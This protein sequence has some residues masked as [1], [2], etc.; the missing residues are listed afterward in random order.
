MAP[1]KQK[2]R[3]GTWKRIRQGHPEASAAGVAYVCAQR[4][5]RSAAA[6]SASVDGWLMRRLASRSEVPCSPPT[7]LA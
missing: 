2:E 6:V 5:P 4:E 3:R 1:T 7:G